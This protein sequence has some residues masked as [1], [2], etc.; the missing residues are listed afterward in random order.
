MFCYVICSTVI[1]KSISFVKQAQDAGINYYN[2]PD[3]WIC[4]LKTNKNKESYKFRSLYEYCKLTFTIDGKLIWC[5]TLNVLLIF[6]KLDSLSPGISKSNIIYHFKD[7]FSF[8][9]FLKDVFNICCNIPKYALFWLVHSVYISY[10]KTAS[11]LRSC[12]I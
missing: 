3:S 2:M 8:P 5:L 4:L 12:S 10:I 11:G 1:K 9:I 6:L 7:W